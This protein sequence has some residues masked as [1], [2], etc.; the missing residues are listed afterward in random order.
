MPHQQES[1]NHQNTETD[2]KYQPFAPRRIDHCSCGGLHCNGD[3]TAECERKSYSLWIP[4]AGSKVGRQKWAEACLNVCEKE[5]QALER[6]DCSVVFLYRFGHK[7]LAR[8]F[9]GEEVSFIRL[10][11]AI[12]KTM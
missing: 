8:K 1:A 4:T 6:P 10:R 11:E 7:I 5:V 12:G 3:Q 9:P 2:R